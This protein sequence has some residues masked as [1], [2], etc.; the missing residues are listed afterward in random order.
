V[1]VKKRTANLRRRKRTFSNERVET[2]NP[3][4]TNFAKAWHGKKRKLK[5]F[6]NMKKRAE[7]ARS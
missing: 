7:K 5:I 3:G 2:T 6:P 4:S 1:K